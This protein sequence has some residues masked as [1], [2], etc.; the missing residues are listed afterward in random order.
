MSKVIL[1]VAG[2]A[3][4]GWGNCTCNVGCGTATATQRKMNVLKKSTSSNMG[5]SRAMRYAEYCNTTPGL[6]T[7]HNKKQVFVSKA[8]TCVLP[9]RTTVEG[10]QC[11]P[12]V[13]DWNA[14]TKNKVNWLTGG[15]SCNNGLGCNGQ[16]QVNVDNAAFTYK[17]PATMFGRFK[18]NP[19][20]NTA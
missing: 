18:L 14:A 3:S 9:G 7:V 4:L 5:Q 16:N 15:S 19:Y 20:T 2:G 1:P 11:M 13:G 17:Y 12:N 8:P 6:R 10:T